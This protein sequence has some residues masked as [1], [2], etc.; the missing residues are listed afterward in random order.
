MSIPLIRIDNR[1]VEKFGNGVK[2]SPIKIFERQYNVKLHL[3]NIPYVF[4]G[5]RQTDCLLMNR[6]IL[7]EINYDD[8]HVIYP[9]LVE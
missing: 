1:I 6:L 4:T 7:G 3:D 2:I 8:L 5:S 9:S